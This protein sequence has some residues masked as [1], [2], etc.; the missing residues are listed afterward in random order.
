MKICLIQKYPPI[1]GGISRDAFLQ[2]LALAKAGHEVF[3]VTNALEVEENYRC[4]D[5]SH[6]QDI[7]LDGKPEI[8]KNVKLFSTETRHGHFVIPKVNPSVTKLSSL[9]TY[10]VEK[11]DC[12]L[13][14]G[15]YFEPYAMAAHI[16][17]VYTGVPFGIM[18][19]GR[20]IGQLLAC[21]DLYLAYKKLLEKADF[22]IGTTTIWGKLHFMGIDIKKVFY[23]KKIDCLDPFFSQ[24]K[25][26]MDLNQY[27]QIVLTQFT[28]DFFP[29]LY[30]ELSRKRIKKNIPIIGMYS[31]SGKFKGIAD[32]LTALSLLKEAGKAFY[33]IA[34]FQGENDELESLLAQINTLNLQDHVWI[35]P[36]MPY[37]HMGHFIRSCTAV[38]FLEK[39][40]GI[41]FHMPK[42]QDEILASARCLIMSQEIARKQPYRD[43]IKNG[44]NCFVVDPHNTHELAG[45]LDAVISNPKKADQIGENGY[46]SLFLP[47]AIVEETAV[48]RF[49]DMFSDIS[50]YLTLS[51]DARLE[52]QLK[53]EIHSNYRILFRE[54]IAVTANTL[55]RYLAHMDTATEFV[56]L[57]LNYGEYVLQASRQS[58]TTYTYLEDV[59][60]YCQIKIRSNYNKVDPRYNPMKHITMLDTPITLSSVVGIL[61]DVTIE[62]FKV[63]IP[64]SVQVSLPIQ[65]MPEGTFSYV[66]QSGGNYHPLG[67]ELYISPLVREILALCAKKVTPNDI[68][69]YFTHNSDVALSQH[70]LMGILSELQNKLVI[71]HGGGHVDARCKTL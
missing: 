24:T 68:L 57:L 10:V 35:F 36:F 1:Q 5:T 65:A 21:P 50:L 45:V 31:K 12:D 48:N 22:I 70:E 2:S 14:L 20:D 60:R 61:P 33:F 69:D 34:V 16:T 58:D 59:I 42:I 43:K 71:G 64:K 25:K 4:F 55:S 27:R 15:F 28:D 9:A 46:Q 40:F 54:D 26:P 52:R 67:K 6:Y 56:Q 63:D 23:H 53:K 7:G 30:K 8:H 17:S 32:M 49:N 39:N 47:D 29:D 18:H 51:N 62:D 37:W 38:C 66:F 13:I 11:Y 44:E 41:T 3:V 19:G